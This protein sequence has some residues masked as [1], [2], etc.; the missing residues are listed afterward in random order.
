MNR[1]KA[2]EQQDQAATDNGTLTLA[3]RAKRGEQV[4]LR[5]EREVDAVRPAR[6]S[7]GDTDTEF[8]KA[9]QN[10]IRR[11]VLAKMASEL[12]V[13]EVDLRVDLTLDGAI[14]W[15]RWHCDKKA[16][17]DILSGNSGLTLEQVVQLDGMSSDQ[18]RE[19]IRQAGEAAH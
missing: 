16:V 12:G 14:R 3:Q 13:S 11:K 18:I 10:R 19:T 9:K 1:K 15:L 8:P 6:I 5:V 4:R 17:D 2:R 7:I